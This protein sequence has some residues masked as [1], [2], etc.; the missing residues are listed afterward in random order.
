MKYLIWIIRTFT[1]LL[2][3]L[4]GLVKLNDPIGFSFKLEEYFSQSVLDLPFLMP[5]A[6]TIAL[7]VVIVEVLLGVMLL[8]GFKRKITLWSLLL[9]IVGFTFLTFYSA[10]FNKVTDC[11]CFGD[12]VKLT[13]WGSFTKDIVLLI[14]ISVLFLGEK[15]LQPLFSRKTNRIIGGATLLACSGLA[16][17][18]LH[19]LPVVDFRPY[20]IG[21]NIIE[22]MRIPED[23]SKP[24]YEYT[25]QFRAND[26]DTLLVTYGDYPTVQ[27]EFIGVTTTLI[28]EGYEPPI[29]DFTIERNGQD[30]APELLTTEKLMMIVAYDL[31]KSCNKAF[32]N[33]T[34]IVKKA[35]DKGYTVVGLTA[36]GLEAQNIVKTQHGL[37][38]DFYFTDETVLKTIVRAN[39]GVLVLEKG[40]IQQ[41]VHHNDL[42]QLNF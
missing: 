37:N 2:F 22:G 30:I 14:L 10:Y 38:I 34:P 20:A 4:S 40:S 19:H 27:G 25:W 39:P 41:K 15:H 28:K 6:L 5:W 24:V 36:S 8:L 9:M 31:S 7:I 33:L 1:G 42:H 26:V 17:H 23:A 32:S 18:V 3:I 11:G 12:A 29:H 21:A 16:H 13:P 35:Q